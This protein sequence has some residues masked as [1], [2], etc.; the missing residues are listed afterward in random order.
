MRFS[1]LF[2]FSLPAQ[3]VYVSAQSHFSN[4]KATKLAGYNKHNLRIVAVNAD[5]TMNLED[6]KAK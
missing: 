6:L 1:A 4:K 3:I 5:L 2:V